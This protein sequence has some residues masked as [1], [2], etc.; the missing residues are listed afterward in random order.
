MLKRLML[1]ADREH[2]C[3]AMRSTREAIAARFPDAELPTGGLTLAEVARDQRR[4]A[5]RVRW[6]AMPAEER[7]R[8]LSAVGQGFKNRRPAK[9]DSDFPA[10]RKTLARDPASRYGRGPGNARSGVYGGRG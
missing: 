6:E 2:K 5:A 1:P 10:S 7:A 9:S 8:R 3:R 4:A